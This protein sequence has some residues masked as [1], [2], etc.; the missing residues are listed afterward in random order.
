MY[1]QFCRGEHGTRCARF[2]AIK[3]EGMVNEYMQK[4]EELL[5]PLL[6]MADD[7]LWG[8]SR[9]GWIQ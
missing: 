5:A 2:L 1:H 9:M 6:E 8:R 7:V 3:Q 4:F